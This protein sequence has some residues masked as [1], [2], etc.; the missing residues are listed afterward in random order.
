MG[1]AQTAHRTDVALDYERIGI[2]IGTQGFFN[3]LAIAI[4]ASCSRIRHNPAM[5]RMVFAVGGID[6]GKA[7]LKCQPALSSATLDRISPSA[8]IVNT[9]GV[10]A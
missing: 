6:I 4:M 9:A 2:G 5:V 3:E 8:P 1:R 10:T 7:K